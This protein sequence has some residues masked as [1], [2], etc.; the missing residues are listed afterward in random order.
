MQFDK[1]SSNQQAFEPA[2]GIEGRRSGEVGRVATQTTC[3]AKPRVREV[4]TATPHRRSI[5]GWASLVADLEIIAA[6]QLSDELAHGL[7]TVGKLPEASDLPPPSAIAAVM[8][9]A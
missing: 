2:A 1:L 5:P 8:V 9:S 6:S 3:R 4:I 7:G